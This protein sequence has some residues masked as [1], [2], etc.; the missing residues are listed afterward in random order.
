MM[1]K[2]NIARDSNGNGKANF[3][4]EEYDDAMIATAK[5][6]TAPAVITGAM[7]EAA[8]RAY[9]DFDGDVEEGMHAA[10]IAALAVKDDHA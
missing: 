9:R 3:K 8:S 1:V 7:V 10:L 4:V 2:L 6:V 5:M